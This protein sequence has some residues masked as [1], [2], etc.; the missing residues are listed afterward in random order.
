MAKT[1]DTSEL[2]NI[3]D[4]SPLGIIVINN[5]ATIEWVNKN[6]CNI[7]H[8]AETDLVDKTIETIDPRLVGLFA[9]GNTMYLK[10]TS[11]HDDIWLIN[12]MGQLIVD[13]PANF[14]TNGQIDEVFTPDGYSSIQEI[15]T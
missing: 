5:N 3:V 10:A 12:Q 11:K 9:D 13:T 15:Y 1:L 14:K 8:C 7:L 6:M 2:L 4:H